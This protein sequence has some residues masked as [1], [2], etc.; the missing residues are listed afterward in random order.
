MLNFLMLEMKLTN[1]KLKNNGKEI[2]KT[3]WL[4]NKQEAVSKYL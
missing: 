1:N 4:V 3:I 2:I